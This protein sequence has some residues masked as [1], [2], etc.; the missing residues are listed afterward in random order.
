MAAL[1]WYPFLDPRSQQQ[2]PVRGRTRPLLPRR[3][4]AGPDRRPPPDRH[5]HRQLGLFARHAP[6][7]PRNDAPLWQLSDGIHSWIHEVNSKLPFE[8]E[9][10]LSFRAAET[11]DQIAGRPPTGIRTANWDY[12]QGT[13]HLSREMTLLYGSSP[14]VSIP[15]STKSTASSRSRPNA[16][17]PSAPPRRWTRSPAAP[18]P[19]SAPPTG[20]IRKARS[21]SAAK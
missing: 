13:L 20:T 10:D 4:D 3:R 12:S 21:T 11:L 9:R 8:A 2:A 19:A 18:R 15:G 6:P 14:M 1:R 7:Q 17:S 5:P 16:T